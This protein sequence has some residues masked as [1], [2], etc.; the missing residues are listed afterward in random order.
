MS[1]DKRDLSNLLKYE[2]MINNKKNLYEFPQLF[3][4]SK[5]SKIRMWKIEVRI[6][7]KSKKINK[8]IS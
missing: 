8:N 3:N 1:S 7:K 2:G 4:I 6:I 5:T